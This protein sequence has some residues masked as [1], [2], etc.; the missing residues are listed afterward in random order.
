MR[1][2]PFGTHI[3]IPYLCALHI[4]NTTF[5][6]PKLIMNIIRK[7]ANTMCMEASMTPTPSPMEERG[8]DTMHKKGT[9]PSPFTMTTTTII[10]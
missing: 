10:P 8:S 1:T 4:A 9:T 3:R 5:K 6:Q 7:Q 2:P